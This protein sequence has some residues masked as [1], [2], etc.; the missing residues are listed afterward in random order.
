[1]STNTVPQAPSTK[2]TGAKNGKKYQAKPYTP[3]DSKKR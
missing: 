3:G 1:M 2:T